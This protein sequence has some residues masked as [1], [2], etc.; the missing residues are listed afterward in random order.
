[1]STY[2]DF[3]EEEQPPP[4]TMRTVLRPATPSW[5]HNASSLILV[6]R[7]GLVTRR[8][9]DAPGLVR[10]RGHVEE[11]RPTTE[12]VVGNRVV[13]RLAYMRLRRASELVTKK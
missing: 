11:L 5:P 8:R 10:R 1:M 7:D 3:R 6:A 4:H 2:Y 9:R 12:G 13:V